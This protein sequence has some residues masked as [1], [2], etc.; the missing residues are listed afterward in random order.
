MNYV[1]KDGNHVI[2]IQWE[3][4]SILFDKILALGVDWKPGEIGGKS[5]RVKTKDGF[6]NVEPGCWIIQLPLKE[7][8]RLPGTYDCWEEQHDR[9]DFKVLLDKDFNTFFTSLPENNSQPV[10]PL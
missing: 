2:A 10:N 6:A 8:Q 4:S 5:F 7:N 3:P 9:P 1:D